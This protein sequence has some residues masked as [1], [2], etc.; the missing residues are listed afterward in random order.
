MT[1]GFN[2]Y[3]VG[4]PAERRYESPPQPGWRPLGFILGFA[5]VILLGLALS[6]FAQQTNQQEANQDAPTL[7]ITGSIP[8]S[9]SQ[10]GS[11]AT[12]EVLP[13]PVEGQIVKQE[14]DTFAA[15]E[16]IGKNVSSVDG[17]V[18]GEV[19]DLLITGDNRIAGVIL[20]VGGFLG[21]GAKGVAVE[22]DRLIVTE[23]PDG[24]RQVILDLSV[25]ELE[26]AP[27]FVSLDEQRQAREAEEARR[28]QQQAAEGAGMPQ[29]KSEDTVP[30]Q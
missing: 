5:A 8:D 17:E 11:E 9:G 12:T 3:T 26:Q 14:P 15:S 24:D 27:A 4:T 19:T 25:E 29:P 7:G 30:T 28:A 21:F 22:Y 6:A 10:S 1:H 20:D 18:L 23:T 2:H 16:L 13:I